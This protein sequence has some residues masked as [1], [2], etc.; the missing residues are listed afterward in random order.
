ME[1]SAKRCGQ[2]TPTS[3]GSA[4]AALGAAIWASSAG[5]ADPEAINLESPVPAQAQVQAVDEAEPVDLQ[6]AGVVAAEAAAEDSQQ[7]GAGEASLAVA[8][9]PAVAGD[10]AEAVDVEGRVDA[11]AVAGNRTRL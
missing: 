4:R 1:P 11:A 3:P 6:A 5:Q 7:A 2:I 8:A 9:V 10:A